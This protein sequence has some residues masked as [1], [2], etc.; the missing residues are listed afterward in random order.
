MSIL[1]CRRVFILLRKRPLSLRE[2]FTQG[3]YNIE[4]FTPAKGQVVSDVGDNYG[5]SSIWCAKKFGARVVAFEPLKDVFSELEKNKE[6]NSPDVI[7]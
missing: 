7:A 2:I 4:G 3:I 5:D 6:L 1:L